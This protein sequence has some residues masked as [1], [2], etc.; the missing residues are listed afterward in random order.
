MKL[1]TSNPA[2][3][4]GRIFA[5]PICWMARNVFFEPHPVAHNKEV[6]PKKK[7]SL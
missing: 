3:W 5:F 6:N 1:S 4:E 7:K 2:D